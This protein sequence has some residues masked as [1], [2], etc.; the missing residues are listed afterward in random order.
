[1]LP[2]AINIGQR[3]PLPFRLEPM[4]TSA[5]FGH[6]LF[7]LAAIVGRLPLAWQR[8]LGEILGFVSYRFNARTAKVARRNFEYSNL[9]AANQD[10]A[11]VKAVMRSTGRNLL[12]TLR[13]WT[14]PRKDNLA[15]I[16]NVHGLEHLRAAQAQKKGLIIAAPHYGNWELLI[17]YMASLGTFALVY[18]VPEKKWGDAFLRR[19]RGGENVVLVPAETNAMRPLWKT[20]QAGGTVGITPDQQPKFGGGE[21]AAFFGTQAFTLSLIPKLAQRS[22][23]PVVFAYTE[24]T[25]DGFDLFFETADARIYDKDL[26]LATKEMNAQVEAIAKRDLRQ[27][28]W[29]YKRYTLRPPNSG[30]ENPYWPSCY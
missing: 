22:Q 16:K 30:E 11:L 27:Y 24:A 28:Q 23:A 29:T 19:A 13:V 18:R 4:K 5:W 17:E 2:E 26:L 9:T 15:L 8:W 3:R 6:F 25:G 12:E 14:R 10:D 20:L 1:M 7:F 21:F